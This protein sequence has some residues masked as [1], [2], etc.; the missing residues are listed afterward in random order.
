MW[1][2]DALVK[3]LDEIF[4]AAETSDGPGALCVGT[5]FPVVG[6]FVGSHLQAELVWDPDFGSFADSRVGI[7]DIGV[8]SMAAIRR[9]GFRFVGTEAELGETYRRQGYKVPLL[10]MPCVAFIPWPATVRKGKVV[11]TVVKPLPGGM[12]ILSFIKGFTPDQTELTWN[13]DSFWMEDWIRPNGWDCLYPYWPTSIENPKWLKRRLE[14]CRLLGVKPRATA[15]QVFDGA[16]RNPL[17]WPVVPPIR[18]LGA[19]LAW[20]YSRAFIGYQRRLFRSL[21]KRLG[22]VRT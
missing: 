14:A 13:T 16:S 6:K 12:P 8:F 5:D 9:A 19:S 1:W 21:G 18:H 7:G 4:S 11:G 22:V 20:G 2:S 17:R 3:R 15:L 10:D